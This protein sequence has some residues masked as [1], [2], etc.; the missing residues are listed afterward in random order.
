MAKK[1]KRAVKAGADK[2]ARWTVRGV[3]SRLQKAAGDVARSNGKTLGQWLSGVVETALANAPE[4]AAAAA[5]GWRET[6][7]ARLAKLEAAV[8]A[9]SEPSAPI[10]EAGRGKG[11]AGTAKG[12][13]AQAAV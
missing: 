8:P 3:P 12:E 10:G 1:E 5:N 2:A 11:R 13:S 9:A 7:E 6:I 4:A